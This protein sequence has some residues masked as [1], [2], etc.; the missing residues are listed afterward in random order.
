MWL[1]DSK[2]AKVVDGGLRASAKIPEFQ[3][4]LKTRLYFPKVSND[5][6][7]FRKERIVQN[8]L[9]TVWHAQSSRKNWYNGRVIQNHLVMSGPQR[10][11]LL[12]LS[13]F[14]FLSQSAFEKIHLYDVRIF[15]HECS[16]MACSTY[17][18]PS[19]L[20]QCR[21]SLS[22]HS[23]WH[24][25]KTRATHQTH[26]KTHSVWGVQKKLKKEHAIAVQMASDASTNT[27]REVRFSPV[28]RVTVLQFS[29]RKLWIPNILFPTSL[30]ISWLFSSRL[31]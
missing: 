9:T 1:R 25:R 26:R 24:R 18:V 17:L 30:P 12:S 28:P 8:L 5:A 19:L 16:I 21:R 15:S 29:T 3:V 22:S 7:C 20:F 6:W 31:L 23:T 4:C 27:N 10:K 14:L 13:F 11:L 2:I